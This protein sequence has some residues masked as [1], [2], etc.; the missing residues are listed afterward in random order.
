MQIVLKCSYCDG[1][2]I[3]DRPV[4]TIEA[5]DDA[6]KQINSVGYFLNVRGSNMRDDGKDFR[7][8]G[9]MITHIWD[10]PSGFKLE[11]INKDKMKY[12][13]S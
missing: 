11:D 9:Y 10:P 1:D 12:K 4:F 2:M 13:V 8:S 5:N 7:L 6:E 3:T